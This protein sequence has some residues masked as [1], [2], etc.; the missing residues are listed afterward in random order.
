MLLAI[1]IYLCSL[2]IAVNAQ[3]LAR[4]LIFS[5]TTGFRHDSIPTAIQTLRNNSPTINVEFDATEDGSLFTDENLARYN[6]V[7]FLSTTGDDGDITTRSPYFEV[8]PDSV[9]SIGCY[10][11]TCP[12]NLPQ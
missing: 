10:W 4:V 2:A 5:A 1:P 9:R 6:A 12:P 3:S 11:T 7:V 8:V